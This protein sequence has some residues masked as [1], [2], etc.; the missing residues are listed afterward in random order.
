LDFSAWGD[1]PVLLCS[2]AEPAHCH[3]RV[4]A[5]FLARELSGRLAVSAIVHL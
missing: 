5:E 2:E 1:R 3:R 4:A